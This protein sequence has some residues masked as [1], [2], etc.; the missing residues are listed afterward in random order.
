M[1]FII[2]PAKALDFSIKRL[3]NLSTVSL[4]LLDRADKL[5]QKLQKE[6]PGS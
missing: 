5:A 1:L 4:H 2:S 3:C 6:S